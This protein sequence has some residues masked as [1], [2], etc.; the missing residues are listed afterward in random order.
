[1]ARMVAG[2][3]GS[4]SAVNPL[5]SIRVLLPVKELT[6]V[7]RRL[8]AVLSREERRT[9]VLTM[10]RDVTT[11]VHAAGLEA[12]VLSPDAGVLAFA[13]GAGA[14]TIRE[15]PGAAGLSAALERAIADEC[16]LAGAVLVI[17]PDTPLVTADE[18]AVL[19]AALPGGLASC[20]P[21]GS[22][23]AG[24]ISPTWHFP[25]IV[26][27]PDRAGRGTNALLTCPPSVVPLGYGKDSLAGHLRA[28]ESRGV[29]TR[30]CHLPALALDVDEPE[31]LAAVAAAPGKT[32]TQRYLRQI[33]IRE[34]I[35]SRG[36]RRRV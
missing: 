2:V 1:M 22:R 19:I 24:A 4:E 20:R 30:I 35:K 9:L 10:L 11:A 12:A 33:R 21:D 7:K 23:D 17:L 5:A 14:S 32:L 3:P 16:A 27:A 29:L 34:R 15:E 6:D 26:L 25:A 31:D 18:L 28:A 36:E 8:A 13:R